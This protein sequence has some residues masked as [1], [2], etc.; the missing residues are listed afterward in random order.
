MSVDPETD[1]TVPLFNPRRDDW[2][3][4]FLAE[5]GEI[6]GLTPTGRATVQL[7]NFNAPRRAELR[8][9]WTED[10]NPWDEPDWDDT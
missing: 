5:G 8:E 6:V 10:A 2:S 9:E 1:E 4:H 3:Q 7:M